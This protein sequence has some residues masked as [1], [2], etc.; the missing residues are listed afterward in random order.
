MKCP[1]C[2]EDSEVLRSQLYP[3]YKSRRRECQNKHRFTT[4]ESIVKTGPFSSTKKESGSISTPRLD[5]LW[6]P[7]PKT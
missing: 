2:G 1:Q 7:K 4:H 5:A 6:F 3:T